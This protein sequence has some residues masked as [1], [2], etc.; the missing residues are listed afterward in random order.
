MNNNHNKNPLYISA[1]NI[2]TII[3]LNFARLNK[4]KKIYC[5]ILDYYILRRYQKFP[6]MFSNIRV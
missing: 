2:E 1:M 5:Y 6:I 3:Y 4:L